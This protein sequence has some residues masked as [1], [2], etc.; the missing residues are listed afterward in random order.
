MEQ[1]LDA[2]SRQSVV[3]SAGLAVIDCMPVMEEVHI[4]PTVEELGN[5][6]DSLA[7]VAKS[8]TRFLPPVQALQDYPKA[9]AII[10]TCAGK[11]VYHKT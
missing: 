9:S 6:I 7:F 1:Y 2:Y 8:V 10:A 5:A 11:K 4:E 3:T